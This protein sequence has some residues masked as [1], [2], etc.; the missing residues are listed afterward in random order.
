MEEEFVYEHKV[1]VKL[2]LTKLVVTQNN[3]TN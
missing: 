2:L 1:A 3:E